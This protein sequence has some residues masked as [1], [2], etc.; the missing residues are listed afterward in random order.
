MSSSGQTTLTTSSSV[1]LN[2]TPPS[3]LLLTYYIITAVPVNG[4]SSIIQKF[5]APTTIYTMTGLNSN[6]TYSFSLTAV[7]SYG[8]SNPSGSLITST[9]PNPPSSLTILSIAYNTVSIGFTS[10]YG[11][12]SLYTLTIV[13]VSG[14]SSFSSNLPGNAISCVFNSLSSS[15]YYNI[16]AVSTSTTGL[17]SI[18]NTIQILTTPSAPQNFTAS[19]A[20]STTINI[21]FT[22][23]TINVTYFTVTAIPT[24]GGSTITQS[25][26]YPASSYTITSLVS[27]TS[28]NI[29]LVAVNNS[30]SSPASTV[31]YS[32][33]PNAPTGLTLTTVTTTTAS[34]SFTPPSGT[35]TG[36]TVSAVDASGVAITPQ[37]FSAPASSYTI[38]GLTAAKSYTVS[39]VANSANSSSV[40]SSTLS[41]LTLPNPPTALTLGAITTTTVAFTFTPPT[42]ILTGYTVSA[43]DASGV[44]IT[45]QT[46][47]A[48]ASSYTITGLTAGKLYTVSLVANNASGSSAA[49]STLTP[50]TVN[51]SPTGLTLT[52]TTTTT[53]LFSFTPPSGLVTSYTVTAVPTSGTTITQT[54]SAPASSYTITGM[55]SAMTYTIRLTDTNAG[56]TS[57]ASTSISATTYPAAPTGLTST[58]TT[59]NSITFSFTA[60]TGTITSYIVTAVPSSG[61]TVTQTFSA[62]ATSYTITTLASNTTYTISLQAVNSV[63]NSTSSSTISVSTLS[64][65]STPVTINNYV[66][67]NQTYSYNAGTNMG[68]YNLNPQTTFTASS[69][70]NNFQNGNYIIKSNIDYWGIYNNYTAFQ[71]S[72]TDK[73][74]YG[75]WCGGTEGNPQTL[76]GSTT[77]TGSW[78]QIKIPVFC[79]MTSFT[80]CNCYSSPSGITVAGSNNETTWSLIYTT[81]NTG[82]SAT[83]ND[84][85]LGTTFTFNTTTNTNYYSYIRFIVTQGTFGQ[86][87]IARLNFSGSFLQ[88]LP[89]LTP[90]VQYI[91]NSSYVSSGRLKNMINGAYDL[92]LN[93]TTLTTISSKNCIAPNGSQA[94]INT[95]VT[96]NLLSLFSSSTTYTAMTITF[97]VYLNTNGDWRALFSWAPQYELYF[98]TVGSNIH[99]YTGGDYDIASVTLNAWTMYTIVIGNSGTLKGYKN[100]NTTPTINTTFGAGAVN[101]SQSNFGIFYNQWGDPKIDGYIADFRIYTKEL[102]TTEITT[103]YTAGISNT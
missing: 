11:P 26:N 77:Y 48:P 9:L 96:N 30:G 49:S 38:T 18:S 85:V 55:A 7:N 74:S 23:Y 14:G 42:G 33:I 68:D 98:S 50:T 93:S 40:S 56:G 6:T 2:F 35:L 89:T 28:Y 46:F 51:N 99:L 79:N 100:N 61:T 8:K 21:A 69:Q 3:N 34:I 63:G 22:A 44:A 16:S 5:G 70:S 80:M 84:S 83:Q 60:P 29:S 88:S 97:W 24:G 94:M 32:T 13:P 82:M 87:N 20:T 12:I 65:G 41:V 91:F 1:T 53:A 37:T 90:L 36:Y 39:L 72:T 17:S 57:S 81:T 25:F 4:G 95:S 64:S 76:V 19:S 71:F 92:T 54:F 67:I 59:T 52:S 75:Y 47:T 58:A 102:S 86:P 43:I 27:D 31:S 101:I 45:P 73:S 66:P 103:I 10:P 62:P 78:L 15:T